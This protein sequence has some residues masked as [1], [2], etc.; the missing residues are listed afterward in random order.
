MKSN[1]LVFDSL[2]SDNKKRDEIIRISENY[3]IVCVID[4]DSL[5][6]NGI[7]D[8][9][10]CQSIYLMDRLYNR[11]LKEEGIVKRVKSFDEIIELLD[12]NV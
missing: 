10:C 4:D 2:I 8:L 3:E 12:K 1:G 6:V 7:K 9:I 5:I 11:D